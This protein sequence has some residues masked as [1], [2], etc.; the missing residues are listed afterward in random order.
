MANKKE[1][2]GRRYVIIITEGGGMHLEEFDTSIRVACRKYLGA[3]DT[4][5]MTCGMDS[6]LAM[7]YCSHVSTDRLNRLASILAQERIF[8][9]VAVLRITPWGHKGFHAK[10]GKRIMEWIGT[11]SGVDD[12]V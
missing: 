3:S 8:G 5:L 9:P 12:D 4:E 6:R 10:L 2:G 1:S 7:A 11:L